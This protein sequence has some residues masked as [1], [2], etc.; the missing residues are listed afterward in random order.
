MFAEG[1]IVTSATLGIVGEAG[2]EAIIPLSKLSSVAGDLNISKG[3]SSNSEISELAQEL[4]EIK[5]ALAEL[6]KAIG[7]QPVE[8]KVEIDGKTLVKQI[9]KAARVMGKGNTFILPK[10]TVK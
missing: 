9:T 4:S 6:A 1:G 5:E 10:N 8:T 2:P 3:S 7:S